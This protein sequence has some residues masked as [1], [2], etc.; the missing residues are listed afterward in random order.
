MAE[1]RRP[2]DRLGRPKGQLRGPRA[3]PPDDGVARGALDGALRGLAEGAERD[4]ALGSDRGSDLGS[5]LGS[6]LG[7]ARGEACGALDLGAADGSERVEGARLVCGRGV[8]AERDPSLAAGARVGAAR[9]LGAR[10]GA[11]L[12]AGVFA[13]AGS[14]PLPVDGAT[15][16]AVRPD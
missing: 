7:A 5:A 9:S 3:L 2:S 6:D 14:R 13:A 4:P 15:D 11:A 10:C 12:G 8:G 16:G 1:V